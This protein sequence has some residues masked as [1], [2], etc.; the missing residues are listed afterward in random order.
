MKDIVVLP[1]GLRAASL[2]S[3]GT[4]GVSDHSVY[5]VAAV[6]S[7]E[8]GMPQMQFRVPFFRTYAQ[9]QVVNPAE[10]VRMKN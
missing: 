8:L 5:G 9:F 6:D 7:E 4:P 1:K 3:T 10:S 2:T